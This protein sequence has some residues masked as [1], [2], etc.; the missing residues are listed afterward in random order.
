MSRPLSPQPV[1][2]TVE[3]M[4]CL[5]EIIEDLQKLTAGGKF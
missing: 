1:F 5:R 3:T 2:V 4:R